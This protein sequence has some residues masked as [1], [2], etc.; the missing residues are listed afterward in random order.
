M[1]KSELRKLMESEL[2][3]ISFQKR[4]LYKTNKKEVM[5]LYNLL[6]KEIFGNKLPIAKITLLSKL[7]NMWGKCQAAGYP[8]SDKSVCEITVG[9]NWFCV[10]WLIM[11]LAHEMSHQYQWEV[12]GKQRIKKG[13]D[14]IMSHGPSFYTLRDKMNKKGIPLKKILHTNIW[15]EKQNLLKC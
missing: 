9:T 7:P 3:S 5:R 6:N 15:F 10:Q 8:Y 1:S 4:R 11:T 14:P 2:P 12:L 13:K